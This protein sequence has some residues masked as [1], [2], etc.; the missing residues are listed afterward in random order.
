M[1]LSLL[2]LTVLIIGFS[3]K[4]KNGRQSLASENPFNVALNKPIDYKIVTAEHLKSYINVSITNAVIDLNVIKS[5]K[6]LNFENTF[7][8]YDRISNELDK[9][10]SNAFVLNW[11]STDSFTRAEGT[12]GYQKIDSLNTE[13]GSDKAL[14]KI[15][16]SY[17]NSEKGKVLEGNKKALV[18]KVL[19]GF[20]H[21]GVNLDA[22]KL[23][24]YKKLSAEISNLSSQFSENMNTTEDFLILND[25]EADGLP[26][27]FKNTYRLENGNYKIPI[28]NATGLVVSN[29]SSS[30]VRKAYVI[31]K[32][33]IAA[34]QNLTILDSL[35]SKR[36]QL[37]KLMGYNSYAGYNLEPK[38]AKTPEK[39]W[40]FIN[41]L[42]AESK[43]KA[44]KD[45]TILKTVRNKDLN[46]PND[47]SAINPW[48]LGY[49]NNQLLKTKYKLDYQKIRD[50]L[51]MEACLEGMLSL[52]QELLGLEFRKV[53]NP[54]VWY[55]DVTMYEVYEG[56]KLKGRFYLDLYPRPNKE[57]WFYKVGLTSGSQ[58]A[59]GYEVPVALLL[60]NFTKATDELPSLISF[61]ELNTLFH[62]FGHIVNG[63]SYEG[64]FEILSSTK[65][66]FGEA[67]SQIFENWIDDY[68]ILSSFAKH[69]KTG[70]V[71]PKEIFNRMR[72]AKNVS[73]GIGAQM[74]LRNCLYDMNLYNKYNPDKPLNTDQLWQDIDTQMGLMD[75]YIDGTHPQASWIHINTNPVYYYGYLWSRVYAQD[76]FTVFEKNGLRDTETGIKYR[77]LILANG[78][79]RDIDEA[80]EEF[81]GRPTNNKAYIKSLGLE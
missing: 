46:T 9:A 8:A 50:Y 63:M 42:L 3:N 37:G 22:T 5:T 18:N 67:M 69:Y 7:L 30:K 52:Y 34:D 79:Q 72:A 54:S 66:D 74:S 15:F 35:I 57:T 73:S 2:F 38:M 14:F 77:K 61:G 70:E 49:Y 65:R 68:D 16:Q 12:K 41:G 59:N 21:S 76:M 58:T 81:L 55:E 56:E 64:E 20:K 39:V 19:G 51:P 60:G 62:E 25:K 29:A 36:Y 24:T 43:E 17:A 4:P 32:V 44:L 13:I 45:I 48:D 80:V 53:K 23:A 33:N 1:K 10:Y 11:V 27:N 75:F 28:I 78:S 31:K 40:E 6:N 71:F 26:E 47:D